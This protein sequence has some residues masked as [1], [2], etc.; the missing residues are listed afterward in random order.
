MTSRPLQPAPLRVLAFMEANRLT[1]PAKNLIELAQRAAPGVIISIATFRR[2]PQLSRSPFMDACAEA[3]ISVHTVAERR[4]WDPG[5]IPK[6]RQL[7]RSLQADVVQTHSVKS[8]FLVKLSGL[9]RHL[10][11]IAF[12]HGYTN[13]NRK[14][15]LYNR[16]D[17]FSLP[18]A[19]R[20]VTVC[21]AFARQLERRGVPP[22]KLLVR[23]NS[24]RPFIPPDPAAL[25]FTCASMPSLVREAPIL[26]AVG[27]FSREKGHA[28]LMRALAL[29]GQQHRPLPQLVLVGEGPERERLE[30][31]AREAGVSGQV[32][33]AGHQE[34]VRPYYALATAVVIPSHSEGSPNVLL[35]AMAAGVPVIA[36][37]VGGIPE[38]VSDGREALLVPSHS[39]EALAAALGRLLGDE[40]L[41][42]G[43]ATR[44]RA[45]A[46]AFSPEAHCRAILALYH[47]N[48][49]AG[50]ELEKEQRQAEASL[51]AR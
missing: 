41:R 46:A 38:I 20:V 17:R 30:A 8:H 34:E 27:R 12:H 24:V 29:F 47:G 2:G 7:A 16:L 44:A 18:S 10:R 15:E 33:F 13:T 9:H 36:T 3:G 5:V 31:M 21:G 23:H 35:E 4:V 37:A 1:G 43:L 25:A 51:P 28:D 48:S 50:S 32:V 14:M 39:P 11:W 19:Q 49:A 26:L 45:R 22:E 40:E 42:Q 6:M